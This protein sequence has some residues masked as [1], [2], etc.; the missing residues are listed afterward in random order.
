[1]EK[2]EYKF[3][4]EKSKDNADW[5]VGQRN[6]VAQHMNLGGN[7]LSRENSLFYLNGVWAE[8]K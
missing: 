5:E 3:L 4:N 8:F 2:V 1:M 6:R 7:L